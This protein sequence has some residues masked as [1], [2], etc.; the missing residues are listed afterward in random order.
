MTRSMLAINVSRPSEKYLKKLLP[1]H[2][3]QVSHKILKLAENPEA[4]DASLLQG[5]RDCY[6]ADIGEH[7]IIFH[8]TSVTL[9][10]DLIGKRNDDDV[11]RK[12]RR[13]KK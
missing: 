4:S 13:M 9:F 3:R 2:R 11:Y 8:W 6:R 5:F 1:K 10:V 12:L 7:R